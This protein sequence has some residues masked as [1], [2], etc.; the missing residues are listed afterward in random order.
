MVEEW[1]EIEESTGY[2]ISNKGRV[3]KGNII[4]PTYT[5]TKNGIAIYLS[6]DSKA[7]LY[8]VDDLVEKYFGEINT[9]ILKPSSIIRNRKPKKCCGNNK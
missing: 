6:I 1:A 2:S 3:K 4:Y 9:I 7:V 8:L 5:L